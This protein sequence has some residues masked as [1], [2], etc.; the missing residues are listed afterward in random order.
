P[1]PTLLSVGVFQD[2]SRVPGVFRILTSQ[3]TAKIPFGMLSIAVM[4][5]IELTYGDYTSAGIVLAFVSIGQGIAGP[6]TTRLMGR[7]GMRPVLIATTVVCA[8]SLSTIAV[9]TFHLAITCAVAFIV[10]LSTP[11]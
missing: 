4:L 8:T 6:V 5:H 1:A 2:L 7:M 11:P 9:F 10:G 3:V